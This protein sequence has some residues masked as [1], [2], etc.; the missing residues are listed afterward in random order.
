MRDHLHRKSVVV[1]VV[2]L[3]LVLGMIPLAEYLTAPSSDPTLIPASGLDPAI[4]FCSNTIIVE[5]LNAE[6]VRVH[7]IGGPRE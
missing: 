7:C 1:L 6:S 4:V 5:R 2:G 3:V